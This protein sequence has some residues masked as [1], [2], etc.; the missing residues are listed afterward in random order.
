MEES[1][2]Y[3]EKNLIGKIF[4]LPVIKKIRVAEIRVME[5]SSIY[6][7]KNLIGK[8]F[9]LPVIKKFEL[10]KFELWKKYNM[11]KIRVFFW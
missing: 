10:H 5:E 3:R 9:L 4:L 8:I 6:R 1:S 7:G 2:I 11:E